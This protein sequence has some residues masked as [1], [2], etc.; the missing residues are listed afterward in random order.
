[1]TSTKTSNVDLEGE[2]GLSLSKRP[3]I[4]WVK[5]GYI[6]LLLFIVKETTVSFFTWQSADVC[7][8][9]YDIR[10]FVSSVFF[11]GYECFAL[12]PCRLSWVCCCFHCLFSPAAP[13]ATNAIHRATSAIVPTGSVRTE[14]PTPPATS[15]IPARWNAIRSTG[16]RAYTRWVLNSGQYLSGGGGVSAENRVKD[17]PTQYVFFGFYLMRESSMEEI[18][19]IVHFSS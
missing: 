2:N 3:N 10:A 16:N 12:Y 7:N 18:W 17:S 1:M 15:V 6:H 13:T 5:I 14:R 4:Q 19:N 11:G 9:V 8:T